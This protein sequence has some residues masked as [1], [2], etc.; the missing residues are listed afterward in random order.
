M[1][2]V[3][4]QLAEVKSRFGQWATAKRLQLR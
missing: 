3:L 4:E 2:Q 1:L